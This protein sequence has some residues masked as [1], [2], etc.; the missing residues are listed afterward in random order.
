MNY[1]AMTIAQVQQAFRKTD[2]PFEPAWSL[3]DH[4]CWYHHR[5]KVGK[6]GRSFAVVQAAVSRNK[7]EGRYIGHAAGK[8]HRAV[9][10]GQWQYN[11]KFCKYPG[12]ASIRVH[13]RY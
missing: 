5:A 10:L 2:G 7:R 9:R 11:L 12:W 1:K 4:L 6:L 8:A 13:L 3:S